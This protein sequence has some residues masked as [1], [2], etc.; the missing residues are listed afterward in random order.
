MHVLDADCSIGLQKRICG[1]STIAV[2]VDMIIASLV[3]V[4]V[5]IGSLVYHNAKKQELESETMN[6]KNWGD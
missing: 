2:V 5:F 3:L 4:F 6:F 1:Q